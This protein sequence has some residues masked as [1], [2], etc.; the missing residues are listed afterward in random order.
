MIRAWEANGI[1]NDSSLSG[2]EPDTADVLTDS[3][4]YR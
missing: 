3:V 1:N 4:A 2:V